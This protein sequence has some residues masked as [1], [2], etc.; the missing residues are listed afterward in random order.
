FLKPGLKL[1]ADALERLDGDSGD[2]DE[3]L[4]PG[5]GIDGWEV[6]SRGNRFFAVNRDYRRLSVPLEMVGDGAPKLISWEQR[7]APL[8]HIGVLMFSGGTLKA[9]KGSEDTEF[10]AILNT[11]T[12][13]VVAIEPHRQGSKVSTWDWD[14]DKVTIASVDGVTDEFKFEVYRLPAVASSRRRRYGS[15]N[16][17]PWADPWASPGQRSRR[18]QRP[19]RKP[20]TLFE[21]LFN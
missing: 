6:V 4:V 19:R 3:K 10:A 8:K 14:D 12:N 15:P 21:L 18:A 13:T 2:L 7:P 11:K 9:G 16:A 20:K 17:D 1:A 5:L